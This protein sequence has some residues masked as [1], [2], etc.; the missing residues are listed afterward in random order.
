MFRVTE[1]PYM[2]NHRRR[3]LCHCLAATRIVYTGAIHF[4][5]VA[6]MNYCRTTEGFE[7]FCLLRCAI[8]QRGIRPMRFHHAEPYVFLV[9]Q[10]NSCPFDFVRSNEVTRAVRIYGSESLVLWRNFEIAEF[11][12]VF[13]RSCIIAIYYQCVETK[14]FCRA[15]IISYTWSLYFRT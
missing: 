8:L 15:H 11:Y 10:D 2:E 5:M 3:N 12:F 14:Q 7:H 13:P 9:P 1:P 4:S 6:P